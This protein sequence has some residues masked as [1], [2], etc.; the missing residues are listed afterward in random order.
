M[1]FSDLKYYTR[2]INDMKEKK[3]WYKGKI[4]EFDKNDRFLVKLKFI[5]PSLRNFFQRGRNGYTQNDVWDLDIWFTKTI[6][7]IL[8]DLIE[9]SKE[10]CE[11]DFIELLKY[12]RFCFLESQE[13]TCS[14]QNEY[15]GKVIWS[16]NGIDDNSS[17]MECLNPEILEKYR[18]REF[19][20]AAYR[21]KMRKEA[22]R[23]FT[24]N[25]DRLR[26]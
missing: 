3:K 10:F 14:Q 23:L 15:E 11:K 26:I 16:K 12:M 22:L 20:V 8:N 5:F 25:F 2:L 7:N 21:I 1:T 4:F 18:K 9:E 6:I 17:V 19:E 24:E 13:D